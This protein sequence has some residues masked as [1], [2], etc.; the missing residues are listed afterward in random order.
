MFDESSWTFDS[1]RIDSGCS[2]RG[3]AESLANLTRASS[4]FSDVF[5]FLFMPPLDAYEKFKSFAKSLQAE[6]DMTIA[7]WGE[8]WAGEM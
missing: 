1:V 6:A 5:C 3:V 8:G 2:D 7:C 4:F